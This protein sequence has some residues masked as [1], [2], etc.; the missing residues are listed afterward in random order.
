[1]TGGDGEMMFKKSGWEKTIYF[2][3]V[4]NIIV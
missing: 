1:M 3:A 4:S 2:G